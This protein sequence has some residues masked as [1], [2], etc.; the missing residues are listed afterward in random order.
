MWSRERMQSPWLLPSR[1]RR[2]LRPGTMHL[3]PDLTKTSRQSCQAGNGAA[4]SLAPQKA[5]RLDLLPRP[6]LAYLQ[7][8]C[9]KLL[10]LGLLK[11]PALPRILFPG[12]RLAK[13]KLRPRGYLNSKAWIRHPQHS[14]WPRVHI[15]CDI[16]VMC[17]WQSLAKLQA[18]ADTVSAYLSAFMGLHNEVV[19]K[20]EAL[21]V[22]MLSHIMQINLNWSL[23][24]R[25]QKSSQAQGHSLCLAVQKVRDLR[26]RS[27]LPLL[28]KTWKALQTCIS[29]P[30]LKM[31]PLSAFLV[32]PSTDVFLLHLRFSV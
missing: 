18:K 12:H 5:H 23:N 3:L 24:P 16:A 1:R 14:H 30:Y 4:S 20:N 11:I 13:S 17:Q 19:L 6:S 15:M 22:M 31:R 27:E 21:N 32:R 28:L 25:M 26:A 7:M 9:R 10:F 8:P 2:P 29:P